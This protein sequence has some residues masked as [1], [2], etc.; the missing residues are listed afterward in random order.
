MRRRAPC[1]GSDSQSQAI[2]L[3][4]GKLKE[5]YEYKSPKYRR[6]RR[7][8]MQSV[9]CCWTEHA[10]RYGS[11]AEATSEAIARLKSL[12]LSTEDSQLLLA[13]SLDKVLNYF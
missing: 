5:I 10:R 4:G 3:K 8:K 7:W 11:E 1:P 2:A 9:A 6:G 12:I 13:S